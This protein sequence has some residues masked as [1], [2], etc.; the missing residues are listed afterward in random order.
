[1]IKLNSIRQKLWLAFGVIIFLSVLMTG[2]GYYS[3]QQFHSQIGIVS[4]IDYTRLQTHLSTFFKA[5]KSKNYELARLQL[6]NIYQKLQLTKDKL[7]NTNPS[8]NQ[9]IDSL[10]TNLNSFF[11]LYNQLITKNLEKG[12]QDWGLQGK[13]RTAIHSVENSQQNYDKVMMLTL[14]R[15]EKDFMLRYNLSYVKKFNELINVFQKSI[16]QAELQQN[17]ILYQQYFN[18]FVAIEQAIGF[19]DDA[20][21]KGKLKKMS[22]KINL[23]NE[24]L[25][26]EIHQYSQQARANITL[27]FL[28]FF[29]IQIALALYFGL[30]FSTLISKKIIRLKKLLSQL[31]DGQLIKLPHAKK[32]D[33]IGQAFEELGKLN[34]RISIATE[35][36]SEIGLGK[37][38]NEY[39]STFKRGVLENALLDMQKQLSQLETEKNKRVWMSEGLAKFM[40]TLQTPQEDLHK[41]NRAILFDLAKYINAQLGAI[42]L[43]NNEDDLNNGQV[44]QLSASYA[45]T[46]QCSAQAE[47][48]VG[49]GLLGEAFKHEKTNLI[50][51]VS[52]NYWSIK[53]GLG[54]STPKNLLL[55]PLKTSQESLG[56]I[57]LASIYTFESQ[58]IEF[59]ERLAENLAYKI[60]SIQLAQRKVNQDNYS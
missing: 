13:L 19:Q 25:N 24:Q 35:F 32:Q 27:T 14:R 54:E 6:D 36:A 9:I 43:L 5:Q 18:Q 1:V 29:I 46:N 51:S 52:N 37:L 3:I 23:F 33:E 44:L 53:S 47:I 4:D 2:I 21:I 28:I 31:A 58:Q 17:I 60:I 56:I 16:T 7:N 15:H 38:Q 40:K 45:Y 48:L 41:L 26:L 55:V 8:I 42:Y 30:R 49:E 20:G 57:E 59:V 10:K 39:P 34:N 50:N 22:D 12:F 11:L